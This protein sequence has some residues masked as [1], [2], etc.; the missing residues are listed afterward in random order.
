[1]LYTIFIYSTIALA[2]GYIFTEIIAAGYAKYLA[3]N[4]KEVPFERIHKVL[5]PSLIITKLAF[6]VFI[7]SG[8]IIISES[9]RETIV[10]IVGAILICLYVSFRDKI[11]EKIYH[12]GYFVRGYYS[13]K[14]D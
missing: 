8:L 14:T 12:Y 3:Y 1:M 6:D 5:F 4:K 2:V 11:F 7:I 13:I 10:Y 9:I